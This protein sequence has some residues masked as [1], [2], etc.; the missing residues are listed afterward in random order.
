MAESSEIRGGDERHVAGQDEDLGS[1]RGHHRQGGS[2]GIPGA[3]RLVLQGEVG[4]IGERGSNGKLKEGSWSERPVGIAQGP[5]GALY[6]TSD[7]TGNVLRI[8]YAP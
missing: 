6:V 1:G 2:H 7:E 5:D 3:A 4:P 8:G